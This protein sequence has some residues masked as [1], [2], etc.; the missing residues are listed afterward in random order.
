MPLIYCNHVTLCTVDPPIPPLSELAKTRRYWATAVFKGVI[1]NQEKNI[2]DLKIS[3]IGERRSTERQYWGEAV[4]GGAV[5]GDCT[6][7]SR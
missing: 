4:K 3:D 2:R 5:L 6:N 7:N 1:N